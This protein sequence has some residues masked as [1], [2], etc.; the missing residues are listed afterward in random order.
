MNVNR[1][2]DGEED[3]EVGNDDNEGATHMMDAPFDGEHNNQ[4][5]LLRCVTV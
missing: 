5:R 3:G 2:P 1:N 4:R